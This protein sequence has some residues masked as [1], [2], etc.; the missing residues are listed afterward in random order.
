MLV[1]S[2]PQ[3]QISAQEAAT[4]G[5]IDY[6][7]EP[8]VQNI[9]R[10]NEISHGLQGRHISIWASHGRYYDQTKATWKWQRP[11]LFGTTEDLYTQTIV[12][13]YL[14][15]MLENAG[16]V[17][18]TPRE[19]D[20]QKNE[21]IVDNDDPTPYQY[22]E[23]A[24]GNDW[25]TTP[26]P[27]FARHEGV[28]YDGENPFME[29]TARMAKST[30]K[31]K[32]A[33]RVIYQPRI[34]EEGRYA[35]YVSYQTRF[36]SIPDAEYRV[37]HKGQE[38]VFRVNQQMGGGTWVYLGTFD[39][40]P[41][42]SQN[43]RVIVS[44]LSN[45]DGVVT[46][47]AVRFGGG[48]GNITRG[49]STSGMARS[50][51]GARYYAQWAGAP[52]DVY[53]SKGG[54]NDYADDINVRSLMTNWLA[55]GSP[56][57]PNQEGKS[58]PI[59]MTLAIH[60]DAGYD[61]DGESI[62]GPLAICTTDFNEG[63]LG[64]GISRQASYN[65]ANEVLSGE[66][67]DMTALYGFW[68]R[69]NFYDR[70]YSETRVP[71]VPSAIIETLSHQSFPDMRHGQ[72]PNF[73][74]A[75]ARSIYKSIVRHT[76]RM[77]NQEYIIQPLAPNHFQLEFVAK[78]KIRLSWTPVADPLE[79]SARA[80]GYNVYTAIGHGS[81]D[82]GEHIHSE[83]YTLRLE[84]DM[85]Y[86]F[87]VTATN[88]GGES[89]PTQTLT[90]V[91]H[92]EATQTILIIDGFQRLSAPYVIHNDSLQGFDLNTD[93]GVS[94]GLTAGWA[95]VQQCFD[96]SRMGIEGPGGLGY[97]GSEM[98]GSYVQGNTFDYVRSHA[99]AIASA[100][101]YNIVSCSREAFEKGQV[102][103][104]NVDGI[105]LILGL[106]KSDTQSV[107]YKTFTPQLQ[108]LLQKYLKQHGRLLVSGAYIGSDMQSATETAFL[109][110]Q[111]HLEFMGKERNAQKQQATVNGLGT[112]FSFYNRL[113]DKH[114]AATTTDILQP[115]YPAYCAMQYTDGT[116]A[117][118]A[119]D[120]RD[121]KTFT[122]GFPLECIREMKTRES[123]F[124]GILAFLLK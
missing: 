97:C 53:S 100:H 105:D 84:P 41:N 44:N 94:Y 51:E 16:A 79:R 60:S 74:F 47:D 75:L 88:G 37:Y 121:F 18:F 31:V 7:G 69:R 96:R 48:M 63:K 33:S 55:G 2:V 70:N 14:I 30:R 15:P 112:T 120:G 36:N 8:W 21:V 82:N 98:A 65:L 54:E 110:S 89:F 90:A 29:G 114:Y 104:K 108:K 26:V 43:N 22:M 28:Y 40:A 113:N 39:F 72:D 109:A 117:A 81:F 68:P 76:A 95:G 66:V 58:V 3:I 25:Q 122:V 49:G 27:G 56:Y 19:R 80:T 35:V 116:S 124:R 9:S 62:Y 6:K 106:Q 10:P 99:T 57:V 4:W 77:H 118:V 103:T 13:P 71:E 73:R 24:T 92:P 59:E 83:S 123:I 17:V 38:T 11:F 1:A 85:P 12:V 87:R 67:R 20:W 5:E 32:K 107:H 111:L 34:P 42:D 45:H 46:T 93:A 23:Q 86:H 115:Q 119:Y 61:P 101:R 102:K 50:F 78:D 52:Y 91:W 64:A